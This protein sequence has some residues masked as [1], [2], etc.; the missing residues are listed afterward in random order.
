[1][2]NKGIEDEEEETNKRK[3]RRHDVVDQSFNIL[4][5]RN[6]KNRKMGFCFSSSFQFSCFPFYLF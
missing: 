2:G 1:M 3:K 4:K 6:E 5:K